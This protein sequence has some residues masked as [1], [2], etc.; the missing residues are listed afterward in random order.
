MEK[1][2]WNAG[3]VFLIALNVI[4]VVVCV[5]SGNRAWSL[6]LIALAALDCLYKEKRPVW[7]EA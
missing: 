2:L 7:L 6:A 4:C 5:L 3:G 1:F